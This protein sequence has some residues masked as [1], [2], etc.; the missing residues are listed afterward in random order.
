[1]H[2]L[3]SWSL[4]APLCLISF[5]LHPADQNKGTQSNLDQKTH[6]EFC[7]SFKMELADLL[8][9]KE[10]YLAQGR[11]V[12]IVGDFYYH[13]NEIDPMSAYYG[14]EKLKAAD[15]HKQFVGLKTVKTVAVDDIPTQDFYKELEKLPTHDAILKLFSAPLRL[16]F[17][18]CKPNPDGIVARLA[19]SE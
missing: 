10:C 14:R 5:Q 12:E 8:T 13:A 4:L 17:E 11:K 9:Q 18:P 7:R 2:K 1:M 16:T 6:A 15:T 19:P 3:S